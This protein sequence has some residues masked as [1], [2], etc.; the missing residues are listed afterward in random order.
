MKRKA[1]RKFI[2]SLFSSTRKIIWLIIFSVLVVLASWWLSRNYYTRLD[3]SEV[4]GY[5]E[6]LKKNAKPADE[7]T[8]T[9]GLEE[10]DG[11]EAAL[12]KAGLKKNDNLQTA[13]ER[14]KVG[15]G[16][17]EYDISMGYGP[18]E[19]PPGFVTNY[20]GQYMIITISD[21]VQLRREQVSVLVHELSHISVW[22]L[23][24]S[25]GMGEGGAQERLVDTSGF[26]RGQGV[27]TLNGQTD[28]LSA[29]GD[30]GYSSEKK[31]FGYLKPEQFGYLLARYCAEHGIPAGS[32]GSFLGPAGRKY[33]DT[34][35]AYLERR[36]GGLPKATG[37]PTGVYWCP[38]CQQRNTVDLSKE[39]TDI[40]CTK[41]SNYLKKHNLWDPPLRLLGQSAGKALELVFAQLDRV[42][43]NIP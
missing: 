10:K 14:M 28:S 22:A 34:G 37:A 41:C 43:A 1:V 36:P 8:L 13:M 15:M 42:A 19:K 40:Q 29:S 6:F 5:Y 12:D 18:Q 39:D 30:G 26:F 2:R 31:I 35:Q 23:D 24:K 32:A 11:I 25:G 3:T 16:L 33:F 17:G 27:L 38:N 20:N 21:K 4:D 9:L 7:L